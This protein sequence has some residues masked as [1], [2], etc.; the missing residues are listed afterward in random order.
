MNTNAMATDRSR[1][2]PSRLSQEMPWQVPRPLFNQALKQI[3]SRCRPPG[4]GQSRCQFAELAHGDRL[5]CRAQFQHQVTLAFG[6]CAGLVAKPLMHVAAPGKAD[7]TTA[8]WMDGAACPRR[9]RTWTP[10]RPARAT[11]TA[12]LSAGQSERKSKDA[13]VQMSAYVSTYFTRLNH[14]LTMCFLSIARCLSE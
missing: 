8:P 6:V 3:S 9:V 12:G 7:A 1:R 14:L 2:R 10:P 13:S 4:G 5:A 11:T